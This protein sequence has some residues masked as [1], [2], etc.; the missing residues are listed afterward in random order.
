MRVIRQAILLAIALSLL[1]AAA[2][3]AA[4]VAPTNGRIVS[5]SHD[6]VQGVT[7]TR[8]A[9][10]L[11]ILTKEDHAAPVVYFSVY[12]K[13]GSR[14]EISGQTGLSHILEHMMFKGT[15]DLPPGSIAALFQKNGG[16][17]NAATTQ[18]YTFYHE[19]IAADRLELAIRIEA[20]RM[21]GSAFDP[22]QLSHEMHVVLSE[23][24][25]DANNPGWQLYNFALL[26]QAFQAN[27]YHWPVIGWIPDVEAVAH[28]RAVIYKYYRDH[29]MPNNATVIICGDFDTKAAVALCQRYFGVYPAG[30]LEQHHITP[31]QPQNGER[32]IILKRPGTVG[33][34]LIGY[35]APALGTKDHYVM[36][37]ISQIL[38]GGRSARLYQDL[39]E[40]GIAED[41]YAD[42]EDHKDPYLFTL[43]ANDR[44]GVSNSTVEKALEDE[45]TKLQTSPVT[46]E[47]LH[48]AFNQIDASFVYQNDSVSEQADQL[49]V[50]ASIAPNG[51]HYL[52]DYLARIHET[53]PADIQRV[54]TEYFTAD[55]RTVAIFE[56]QPIPP[57]TTLAPPPSG[58]HFGAIVP[59]TSPAQKAMLADLSR[60]FS[61]GAPPPLGHRPSPTRVI[62]P[63]GMVVIVE[64]NHAV[65][66]VAITGSLR[67]G[68]MYDP[69]GKWGL[70]DLTAGML[71]RGTTS[72]SALQ[73]ALTLE[74]VGADVGI[75]A[76]TEEAEF[77]GRCL[78]KDFGLTISTLAD[79]LRHPAFPA[80]QLEELR[81]E[82]LSELEQA[83]QEAGGTGGA[84]TEAQ[85][86]FVDSMY[87]KG[88]PYWIPTLDQSQQSVQSISRDDLVAFYSNYYR[89]DTTTMVIV[90]DVKTA[91]AVAAI[92]AVFA[93]WANPSTPK[94]S[95][96]IPNVP[97]PAA[98]PAPI[99]L[100]KPG[101]SQTNILWGFPG[102][103]KRTDKDFY[104]ATIMNF[105]LGGS[106]LSARIGLNLRD[107]EGL[108]YTSYSYFDAA[109]GAGPFTVFVGTNPVNAMRA[110]AGLKQIVTQMHDQGATAQEVEDA[111]DYLTGAYPITLGTNSGVADQL[112]IA[113]D[114]GLGLDY[115][116]KRAGY[117]RSVTLAQVNATARNLLHP[118][119]ATLVISGAAPAK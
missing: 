17:I 105:I 78:S 47:E 51:F 54:A 19:L 58:E 76:D 20:D 56:P 53:T 5:Q 119:K 100:T 3:F 66:D 71:S 112:L 21:E 28:N 84:G 60:E 103:L 10:G 94:P 62:L 26:P 57:G 95:L 77:G 116:E 31:V 8:L 12:Y 29:Y 46:E 114:Y 41:A 55:N 64:E 18:D 113:Q 61:T 25:G 23:L 4:S 16:E 1:C 13:V 63:N 33:E 37:V 74:S 49:G 11:T 80:D 43:D 118:T 104:A 6:K 50:Y 68:S 96:N 67:A 27:P 15:H 36:D 115:I 87:P 39:V 2:A 45:M 82:T 98:A 40:T 86:A 73:L 30:D 101:E 59:I 81:G 106:P 7:E 48:R 111:K 34:V 90:G 38:S 92:K 24:E 69:N 72:K 79:E 117:Y 85:I 108:C 91:Q 88:H 107:R 75:G 110:L 102:E 9:N 32:R 109:H 44:A 70:A 97:V 35:H 89:P 83:K 52:D 14:Y 65:H 42:N 99:M 22:V 93:D